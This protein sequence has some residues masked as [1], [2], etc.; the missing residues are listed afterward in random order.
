MTTSDRCSH[1][2]IFLLLFSLFTEA[3]CSN[4]VQLNHQENP[5]K[6]LFEL[7]SKLDVKS[8]DYWQKADVVFDLNKRDLFQD[9]MM[10][11]DYY[12]IDQPHDQLVSDLKNSEDIPL[13]LKSVAFHY[14]L[15]S[16]LRTDQR[17]EALS[18]NSIK[19]NRLDEMVEWEQVATYKYYLDIA[20]NKNKIIED[21]NLIILMNK[22][23]GSFPY[24][25]KMRQSLRSCISKKLL[26]LE[27]KSQFE[28]KLLNTLT[29]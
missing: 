15:T 21:N 29:L 27:T 25:E 20:N 18:E 24:L 9:F 4:K 22:D 5:I 1:V 14:Y 7:F 12:E 28:I 11:F 3:R 26:T 10:V 23:T 8:D 13:Y 17:N 6:T 16:K 19:L 2:F